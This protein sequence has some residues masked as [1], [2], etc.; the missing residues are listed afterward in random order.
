MLK[1]PEVLQTQ[2]RC[3]AHAFAAFFISQERTQDFGKLLR[4][5]VFH[6]LF[7]FGLGVFEELP[8]LFCGG[9]IL[10]QLFPDLGNGLDVGTVEVVLFDQLLNLWFEFACRGCGGTFCC[11][12]LV[13]FVLLGV[14]CFVRNMIKSKGQSTI[15]FVELRRPR[16]FFQIIRDGFKNFVFQPFNRTRIAGVGILGTIHEVLDRILCTLTPVSLTVQYFRDLRFKILVERG[17]CSRCCI[18]CGCLR[19]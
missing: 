1:P 13:V 7:G 11:G 15:Q 5:H 12:F 19:G 2:G 16:L 10:F 8:H 3:F 17:C 14:V 9:H 4:R 18:L 6:T